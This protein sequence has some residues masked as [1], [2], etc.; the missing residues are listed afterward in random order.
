VGIINHLA[1]LEAA[2]HLHEPDRSMASP[3]P[4]RILPQNQNLCFG[5]SHQLTLY[6]DQLL[7]IPPRV[8]ALRA[9]PDEFPPI[10]ENKNKQVFR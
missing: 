9:D 5:F 7:Y 8:V 10:P 1:F 3:A 2:Q 4:S 6:L